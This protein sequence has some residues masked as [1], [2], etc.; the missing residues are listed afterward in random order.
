MSP[1][2]NGRF[3]TSPKRSDLDIKQE[4]TKG[5]QM[6][7]TEASFY[8]QNCGIGFTPNSY[9]GKSYMDFLSQTSTH[10]NVFSFSSYLL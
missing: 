7:K 6:L 2:G 1:K 3:I 10:D 8:S 4:L 5:S 9:G